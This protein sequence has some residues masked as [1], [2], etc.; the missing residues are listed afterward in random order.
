MLEKSETL[1]LLHLV[2]N[3]NSYFCFPSVCQH[4]GREAILSPYHHHH[5][6]F[7]RASKFRSF[8]TEASLPKTS[9]AVTTL[10]RNT[11]YSCNYATSLLMLPMEILKKYYYQPGFVSAF[12]YPGYHCIMTSK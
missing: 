10:Q 5:S 1:S 9:M 11:I 7:P 12:I 8:L 3:R 6:Y 4:A 2:Q